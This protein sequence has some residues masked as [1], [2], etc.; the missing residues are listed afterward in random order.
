[1][2]LAFTAKMCE[3]IDNSSTWIGHEFSEL[4]I[5]VL[6]AMDDGCKLYFARALNVVY[7]KRN[8]EFCI[9]I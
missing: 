7:L 8:V 9:Q 1:M 3:T 6:T 4:D 5:R 2:W